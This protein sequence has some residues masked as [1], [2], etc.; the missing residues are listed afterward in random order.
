LT[1]L[2][3]LRGHKIG[4]GAYRVLLAVFNY[5]DEHGKNAHPGI[6]RL[7]EDCDMGE[8][9]VRRHLT[10][11]KERRYVVQE[12]RGHSVG[13][14]NLASIYSLA[15]PELPLNIE[16]KAEAPTAHSAVA[17]AHSEHTYRSFQ[18]D[19]PLTTERLSDPSPDPL[20][21]PFTSDPPGEP[22]EFDMA[23][24]RS[25]ETGSEAGAAAELH[26][27]SNDPYCQHCEDS[28]VNV[29]GLHFHDRNHRYRDPGEN[30]EN[31]SPGRPSP[32]PDKLAS[33]AIRCIQPNCP[34]TPIA[35]RDYCPMHVVVGRSMAS[36]L[37]T[38]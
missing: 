36:T 31:K 15:M 4:N 3:D 14:V 6:A 30:T 19:L 32:K 2:K 7:A 17:T 13:A 9:T 23:L 24:S 11:L 20:S 8:S 28:R 38:E 26:A 25:R 22:G 29:C 34:N 21:D 10:W 16:R 1:Y 33:R 18:A 5:T 35:S 37:R 27:V 12:S